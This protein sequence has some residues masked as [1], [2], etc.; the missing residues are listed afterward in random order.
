MQKIPK[1]F[2]HPSAAFVLGRNQPRFLRPPEGRPRSGDV[3]YGSIE[4]IGEHSSLENSSGRI[5]AIHNGT[6]AIFVFGNRYAP[7]YYEGVVPDSFGEYC[8]LLSRSGVIGTVR[9]KNAAVK[10]PTRIRP[11]GR[12]CDAAG[13]PLNTRDH[14]LIKPKKREKKF[15]R[16]RM[17]LVCGSSMNS[18]K[19]TAAVACCWTL[20]AGG[21]TV[22]ASK[23]TGT[24][25]LKD[26]LHMN[27]AGAKNF[28]DFSSLGHPSTYLLEP[29]ALLEVFNTLDLKYANNPRNFWVVEFADGIRQRET[30]MLL[31]CEE[32][33]LRIHRFVFCA[34]DP[35][36]VLGGLKILK[37]EFDLEPDAI[38][39]LCT[40]SPLYLREVAEFTDIPVFNSMDIR[41][42]E[43]APIL[44]SPKKKRKRARAIRR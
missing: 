12:V 8:D 28:T 16:S 22:K 41:L 7:D 20:N 4:R 26:I 40:R 11:L 6:C 3:V 25:G 32:V 38:S 34:N 15:P 43:L 44:V 17:I 31:R 29:D 27:D 1:G 30:A 13:R 33:R 10:D 42:E 35:F 14:P 2:I 37:E 39:G 24:A 9:T 36:G 5:H 21:F 18:G 23:I 19:S